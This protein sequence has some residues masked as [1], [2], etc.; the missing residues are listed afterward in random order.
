MDE[1]FL[2]YKL[3]QV[4][5][6]QILDGLSAVERS[7]QAEENRERFPIVSDRGKSLRVHK[8]DNTHGK[9]GRK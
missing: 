5:L 3:D 6:K 1:K 8:W 2:N 7:Q 9:K 4:A